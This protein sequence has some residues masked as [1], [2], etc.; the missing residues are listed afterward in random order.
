MLLSP[1]ALRNWSF[2]HKWTSLVCT[3]FML[4][5]CI[6]GL[7]LVFEHEIE[8]WLNDGPSY[9]TPASGLP[10]ADLDQVV[11]AAQAQAPDKEILFVGDI[12]DDGFWY[13]NLADTADGQGSRTTVTVDYYTAEVLDSAVKRSGFMAVMLQLHTDL[14]AGL[15]GK[16]FLG[17]MALLLLV[18][19]V[20]GVVLYAP[21]MRRLRFGEVRRDRAPRLK[22]LDLHNLLGIVTLIWVFVVSATGMINTWADLIIATWR[23]DQMATMVAPYAGHPPVTHPG[24]LQQAVHAAQTLEPDMQLGFVAFPGSRL[25]SPHHYAVFMRGNQPLTSRLLK[26]V[27]IDA[28]TL[29]VTDSRPLPWYMT[30]LLLSEPLHFGDYGGMPMKVLWAVLDVITIILLGSG[31]YLWLAKGRKLQARTGGAA[32]QPR[33]ARDRVD[34]LRDR[35]STTVRQMWQTP[36]I[37]ALITLIGLVAA[38]VGDGWHDALSWAALSIPVI[39]IGWKWTRR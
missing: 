12:T 23:T 8:H 27:L 1:S 13:V 29:R 21:F 3:A 2:I 17:F 34:M 19:I 14:F 6:T 4:M 39:V 20:S 26:P 30:A 22:W 31:L 25:S 32:T 16:L 18:A 28:Q 37:V 15:P 33:L 7:P 36:S 11:S 5:L 35:A 10:L 9:T 38:L 24:S